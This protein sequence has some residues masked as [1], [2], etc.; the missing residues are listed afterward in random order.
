MK[1][2]R[3]FTRRPTWRDGEKG[4]RAEARGRP[5]CSRWPQG[6]AAICEPQRTAGPVRSKQG[7]LSVCRGE[8]RTG[9]KATGLFVPGM[10]E[11]E[12]AGLPNNC[13]FTSN[14]KMRQT[15]PQLLLASAL[16]SVAR[17]KSV[18][19]MTAAHYWPGS[20]QPGGPA[21]LPPLRLIMQSDKIQERLNAASVG[22]WQRWPSEISQQVGGKKKKKP[23]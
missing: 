18:W 1:L 15:P 17:R 3:F 8:R 13:V 5:L 14:V 11:V 21:A 22:G 7:L 9:F 6:G 10:K 20:E 23:K 16:I 2:L 4:L 19:F 12:E